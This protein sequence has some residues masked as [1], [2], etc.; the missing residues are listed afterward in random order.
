MEGLLKPRKPRSRGP[1]HAIAILGAGLAVIPLLA[2]ML[3]AAESPST[4]LVRC[5]HDEAETVLHISY[6]IPGSMPIQDE[7]YAKRYAD[8]DEKRPVVGP[9]KATD[10]MG[11]VTTMR[12]VFLKTEVTITIRQVPGPDR[13]NPYQV[14]IHA[15]FGQDTSGTIDGTNYKVA[16]KP[17]TQRGHAPQYAGAEMD[18]LGTASSGPA[19]PVVNSVYLSPSELMMLPHDAR[20]AF[21]V[22]PDSETG[23]GGWI[24]LRANGPAGEVAQTFRLQV[25]DDPGGNLGTAEVA[26]EEVKSLCA[27]YL[28][29]SL[30][31]R[32]EV[33]S[34]KR[35]SGDVYYCLISNAA[36]ANNPTPPADQFRYLFL[37]VFRIS[38]NVAFVIGNLS[39]KDDV[40]V[41][42]MMETLGRISTIPVI[43][44]SNPPVNRGN[45]GNSQ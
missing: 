28:P 23:S 42:M 13:L 44:G 20:L 10:T 5:G 40:N 41:R 8:G 15:P 35:A 4:G 25:L 3:P 18:P 14:V 22:Q 38:G 9:S 19:G 27:P 32:C 39:Q 29:N 16:W 26:E 43:N 37:G 17:V 33:Q 21:D 36:F 7:V 11:T 2:P 31:R 34:V 12:T 1:A 6:Q 24:R 30:E 45:S